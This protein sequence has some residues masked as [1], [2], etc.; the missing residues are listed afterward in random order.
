MKHLRVNE[1]DMAYI[2][3]G[4]G[5]PLVC[6]HG[7]FG[8]FRTWSPVLGPLSRKHRVIA[9]SLRYYF[10]DQWD[11]RGGLFTIAQHISDVIEF[12]A[13][14]DAGPVALL[15][16]S[17]GGHIAFRVAQTR[18]GLLRNLILVEP[19][20]E[21]DSSLAPVGGS[22]VPSPISRIAVAVEKIATGE[23]DD[24]LKSFIDGNSGEGTWERL[25]AS[26]KQEYRDNA[27]TLLG[28][29]NE[30]RQAFTREDAESI[31][32]PTLFIGGEKTPGLLPVVLRALAGSVRGSKLVIIPGGTHHM[33]RE[34]PVQTSAAVLNFLAS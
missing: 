14:L 21:L 22:G 10:P 1:H 16:H 29:I 25:A 28:Q 20:G 31:S 12:I 15:G 23:L 6:V 30:Q 3:V 26:S 18:P 9:L 19:G 8:D 32:V 24:G 5:S 4:Q 2:D 11:G 7:S 34:D 27:R 17:R 13:R 33:I